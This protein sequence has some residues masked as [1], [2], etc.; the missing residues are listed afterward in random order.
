MGNKIQLYLPFYNS[1]N[2]SS[3]YKFKFKFKFQISDVYIN[4]KE[5]F[6]FYRHTTSTIHKMYKIVVNYKKKNPMA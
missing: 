5:V 1:Y 4:G 2:N 3:I 6:V